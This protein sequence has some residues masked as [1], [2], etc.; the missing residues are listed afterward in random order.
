[1]EKIR[2]ES[3]K[4][5]FVR[6]NQHIELKFAQKLIPILRE[7]FLLYFSYESSTEILIANQEFNDLNGTIPTEI[8]LLSGLTRLNLRKYLRPT[9]CF[10][11]KGIS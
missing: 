8:G 11:A 4:L 7:L 10:V 5:D 1:M 6:I 3:V 9:I 2:I